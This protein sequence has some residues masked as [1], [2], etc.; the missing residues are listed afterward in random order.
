SP[1]LKPSQMIDFCIEFITEEISIQKPAVILV[2]GDL[3]PLQDVVHSNNNFSWY[4]IHH[5]VT[6]LKNPE[7]KTAAWKTMQLVMDS[8]GKKK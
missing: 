7:L 5:P 3:M 8:L 1:L 6:L 4:S 2:M